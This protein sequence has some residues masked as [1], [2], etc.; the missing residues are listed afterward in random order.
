MGYTPLS[1]DG[2]GKAQSNSWM[3]WGYPHLG[4]LHITS[5]TKRLTSHSSWVD[6]G[7]F[8]WARF[9]LWANA[10]RPLTFKLAM[11]RIPDDGSNQL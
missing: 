8:S 1:L 6:P 2:F 7:F 11:R 10:E 5:N 3:I 4:N 9:E